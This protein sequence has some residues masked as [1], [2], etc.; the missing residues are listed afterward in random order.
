MSECQCFKCTKARVDADPQPS[1]ALMGNDPRMVRMFL[2][3]TCGNKR[4]PH[5]ADHR[6]QC[7]NSNAPG[8]KGSLYEEQRVFCLPENFDDD[9]RK[10]VCLL[11]QGESCCRYLTMGAD[12]WG[13]AKRGSPSMRWTID[14]RVK[15]GKFGAKG[16][17]C[18]GVYK[19]GQKYCLTKKVHGHPAG[20]ICYE[21]RHHDYGLASDDSRRTGIEHRSMTLEPSGDYPAFA[22][23]V[24]EFK[25]AEPETEG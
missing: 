25:L 24:D 4:C 2:C 13:C 15:E 19:P 12:G 20:T 14:N 23:P 11:G 6:L 18:D 22:V 7:T 5:A 9:W 3:E 1:D 21:A 16:D 10:E 8:Q 17:N